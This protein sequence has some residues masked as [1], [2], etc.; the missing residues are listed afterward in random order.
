MFWIILIVVIVAM[1][2]HFSIQSDRNRREG[3]SD[4]SLQGARVALWVA[5]VAVVSRLVGRSERR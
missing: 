3:K 5:L 2:L 4:G 1:L